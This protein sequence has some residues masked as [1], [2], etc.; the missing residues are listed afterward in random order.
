M[1]SKGREHLAHPS[2]P[3]S[4][5]PTCSFV[6]LFGLKSFLLFDADSFLVCVR[7]C[8]LRGVGGGEVL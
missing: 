1:D 5:N 6:Y 4:F 7:V 8:V 3:L 2:V